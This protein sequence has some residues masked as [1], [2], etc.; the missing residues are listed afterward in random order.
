MQMSAFKQR[1]V[2]VLGL[3]PAAKPASVL[4]CLRSQPRLIGCPPTAP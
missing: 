4:R 3:R 2:C 1:C